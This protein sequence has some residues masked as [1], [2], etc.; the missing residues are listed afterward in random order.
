MRQ[1]PCCY[2]LLKMSASAQVVYLCVLADTALLLVNSRTSAHR[3]QTGCSDC[4]LFPTA[5]T[6][7]FR[8][9][10]SISMQSALKLQV[11]SAFTDLLSAP[12]PPKAP[13]PGSLSNPLL[14][15]I[16]AAAAHPGPRRLP[17]CRL[18]PL[19][20]AGGGSC[21]SRLPGGQLILCSPHEN[22]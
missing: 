21:P 2:G 18:I 6:A 15:Q 16:T 7:S 20:A 12:P 5:P 10:P 14:L 3:A 9:L 11:K 4:P 22:A 13:P 19:P 8:N 1:A 17:L